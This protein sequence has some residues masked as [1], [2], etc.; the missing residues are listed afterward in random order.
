MRTEKATFTNM[1]MVYDG[2]RVLVQERTDPG[3]SGLTFPGGHV[4]L[5]ESFVDA[6]V[7][8]VREESGLLIAEPELC[9]FKQFTTDRDGRYV[10]MLFKTNRYQGEISSSNEGDVFWLDRSELLSRQLTPGLADLL[11]IFDGRSTESFF[12]ADGEVWHHELKR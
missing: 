11:E 3:W 9:G 1:C 10:V 12:R 8:E 2:D 5:G 4:E 7:R 6:V